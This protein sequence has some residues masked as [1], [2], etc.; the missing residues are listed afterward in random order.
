MPDFDY[1]VRTEGGARKTGQISAEN[2][3][4]AFDQLQNQKSTF[5][6]KSFL[7]FFSFI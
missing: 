4:S 7:F 1:I 3:N 6:L 5:S 2:Y